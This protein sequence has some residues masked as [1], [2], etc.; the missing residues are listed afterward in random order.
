MKTSVTASDH[1]GT[2]QDQHISGMSQFT[3]NQMMSHFNMKQPT[4]TNYTKYNTSNKDYIA[5]LKPKLA[6]DVNKTNA[7]K[8]NSVLDVII[9]SD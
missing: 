9:S 8:K 1:I 7:S 3:S 4:T 2:T 5:H 6:I